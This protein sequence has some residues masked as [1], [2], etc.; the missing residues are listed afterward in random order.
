MTA[1]ADSKANLLQALRDIVGGN[2]V[3]T[4]SAATRRY[5]NGFRTPGG[6]A[7]A[8]IRPATLVQQ[9]RVLKAC[10]EADVIV[11]PQASNTSLTGGS[12]PAS[13]YDRDVVIISTARLNG[14]FPIQEGRQVVCLPGATLHQLEKT[15]KPLGR[16]P[17]SVIGSSCFGASVI[18]GLCN[19]SGGAL[20][21]RGPAYTE[22]AVFAHVD[23]DGH[24][25][26]I[27]HLGFELGDA[28]EE[29]LLRLE[30]GDFGIQTPATLARAA[31]DSEYAT[32]VRNV[33]ADTPARFNADPRR[34]FE[35]AGSAGKLMVFAVRLDT[36]AL[37]H[38]SQTFY[39]GSNDTRALADLRRRLLTQIGAVPIAA[40]YL[41]RDAFDLA[42][43]YGK[44]QFL[45]IRF[46]G[47]DR[48]PEFFALKS[49]FDD[50][51]PRNLIDRLLYGLSRLFPDHLPPRMRQWRSRYEHHL[52][53]KVSHSEAA[54]TQSLLDE[55]SAGEAGYFT[56]T[57]DEAARAFLHRFVIAGAAVRY[58]ALH[59]RAV[60][61]IV[62]LDIAL[63]RN[64]RDWFEHLPAEYDSKLLHR[65]YYGHFLCHV[66]HQDYVV[67]RGQNCAAIKHDMLLRLDER[68]ARYPA[69]HNV[70][71]HYVAEDAL[72]EF[73]RQLDP[74]NRFNAGIG[75]ASRLKNYAEC[76]TAG[77]E[78]HHEPAN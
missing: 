12:T 34:L 9:W 28:P 53:L 11:L 41:H 39:I 23:V 20:V 48:L 51:L 64:D 26:L 19:N 13:G 65:I 27:N 78:H 77:C 72:A 54:E 33:D 31:S 73:Y 52:L 36:F 55:W 56:C 69:E 68:G 46:V 38:E 40:E 70:G 18:G 42:D 62:A 50:L 45:T 30:R 22:M 47:T 49:H 4:S 44:D 57:P 3:L 24:L 5:R 21:R 35:A 60:E 61:G 29:I 74:Q 71:N 7:L 58:Q 1:Q 37:E 14:I 43:C 2:H 67:A 76:H 17:H 66:L 6:P 10:V 75:G 63:R 59:P 32:H 15:L 16:E 25:H 8:V